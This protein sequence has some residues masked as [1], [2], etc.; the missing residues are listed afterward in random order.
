MRKQVWLR[1]SRR[2]HKTLTPANL[3][4]W[5]FNPGVLPES[6][7]AGGQL[8]AV[9]KERKDCFITETQFHL[10]EYK[11]FWRECQDETYNQA[12]P[13]VTSATTL[14]AGMAPEEG[15]EHRIS[16]L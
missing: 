6:N 4:L 12:S 13:S 16:L 3:Y 1:V 8:G 14:L 11:C 9:S 15:A 5:L 10:A 7:R 2:Q